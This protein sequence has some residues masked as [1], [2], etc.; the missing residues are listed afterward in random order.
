[1]IN[2]NISVTFENM[3]KICLAQRESWWIL[4]IYILI[5]IGYRYSC[6]LQ[7]CIG[8]LLLLSVSH[9]HNC[10]KK[11]SGRKRN[12]SFQ[13]MSH[14]ANVMT[15]TPVSPLYLLYWTDTTNQLL[16]VLYELR[17]NQ[18]FGKVFLE[19]CHFLEYHFYI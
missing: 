12:L 10:R 5:V 16:N 8:I 1:M 14:C 6:V 17:R 15:N 3:K 4:N 19:M 18:N 9:L 7:I 11:T 2:S 13:S